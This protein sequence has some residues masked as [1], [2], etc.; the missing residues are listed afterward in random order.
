MARGPYGLGDSSTPR[1]RARRAI[2][3]HNFKNVRDYYNSWRVFCV[4]DERLRSATILRAGAAWIPLT[5]AQETMHGFEYAA[6]ILMI[7]RGL[8]EEGLTVVD[9][10]RERYDGEKRNP[11]NEIECGSNYARSMASYA[12]L[13]AFSG[14]EFNLPAGHIGF[15]PL[16]LVDGRFR[17][18]WSLDPA[19]GEVLFSPE[20]AECPLQLARRSLGCVR[21][22]VRRGGRPA[23]Q[24]V[25]RRRAPPR[26][27]LP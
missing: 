2:F 5:Y 15:R 9:A 22:G 23:G 13:N 10:V 21:A 17:C 1:R 8:V 3:R 4:N 25:V 6:A 12:L 27:R 24:L 11:W 14:F 16:R 26:S 7:L 19:W 18:F 20:G